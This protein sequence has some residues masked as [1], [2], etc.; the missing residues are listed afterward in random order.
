LVTKT[1]VRS[2]QIGEFTGD[3]GRLLTDARNRAEGWLSQRESIGKDLEDIR[4]AAN[5]L[6]EQLGRS[7]AGVRRGRARTAAGDGGE[8]QTLR[9]RRKLSAAGRAAIVAA[10]KARWAKVRAAKK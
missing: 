6:L 4:D 5:A 3:L 8:G 7:T 2:D 10:Q 1:S 9:K